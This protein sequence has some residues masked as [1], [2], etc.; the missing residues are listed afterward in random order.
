MA[1]FP[2]IDLLSSFS[3]FFTFLFS[4]A[5]IYGV[6]EVSKVFGAERGKTLNP[7]V[8]V[9]V[10]I[11]MLFSGRVINVMENIAP[12]FVLLVLTAVM[13][14]MIL[15]FLGVPTSGESVTSFF[16]GKG[17]GRT[18]IYFVIIAIILIV[19]Y[20][21]SAEFGQDALEGGTD[22]DKLTQTDTVIETDANGVA[23]D[24]GDTAT[25]DFDQNFGATIFH[26]KV[27]G[28]V[29]ILLIA[30]FTIRL[31]SQKD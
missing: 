29:A 22:T 10:S 24:S 2:G 15:G 9:S 12:W 30:S 1:V 5:I 18:I 31:L 28:M 7:L 26:P 11:M 27:L 17:Q 4:F 21:I 25:D 8:A 23:V 3:A 16:Q 19:A 14:Y 13:I 6:L 20:A